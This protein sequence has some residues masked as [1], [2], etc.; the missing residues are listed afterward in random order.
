MVSFASTPVEA[1]AGDGAPSTTMALEASAADLVGQIDDVGHEIRYHLERLH[2]FTRQ[3]GVSSWTH[4][5]HLQ[6][7]KM[8]VN[9]D[10][11]PAL[12]RLTAMQEQLPGWKQASIDRLFEAA[13]L[14]TADVNS[15]FVAKNGAAG[16]EPALNTEYR[17][18]VAN[19]L[20]H[21]ASL[22]STADAAHDYA[23]ARLK[24]SR[25]GLPLAS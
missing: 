11:G 5:H 24:A 10:L 14:L 8:L 16:T 20:D 3:V 13:R 15:A 1:R 6:R 23:L 12:A 17:A 19:T 21:A 22:I 25:A 2:G 7:V 9:D 4:Y 18:F